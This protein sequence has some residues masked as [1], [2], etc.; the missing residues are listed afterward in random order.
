VTF[1]EKTVRSIAFIAC[2]SGIRYYRLREETCTPETC[3]GPGGN[4]A[5]RTGARTGAR[6]RAGTDA[7]SGTCEAREEVIACGND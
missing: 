7:S 3:P 4:A 5:A 1:L 2:R 6:A